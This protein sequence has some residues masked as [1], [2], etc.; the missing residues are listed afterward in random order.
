MML[1]RVGEQTGQA[2]YPAVNL[3]PLAAIESILG[4]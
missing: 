4:V 3:I 1:A 2:A